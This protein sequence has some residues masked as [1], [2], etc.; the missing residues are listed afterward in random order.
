MKRM[1]VLMLALAMLLS[2]SSALAAVEYP[3]NNDTKLVMWRVIDADIT[4]A[5][6]TSSN[7]T[8]L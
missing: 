5:G 4:G 2:A 6:Y 1:F 7:D 3:V 8:P